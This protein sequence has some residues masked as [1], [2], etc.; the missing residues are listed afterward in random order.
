[1]F[2]YKDE[3]DDETKP[4]SIQFKRNR[5]T[6]TKPDADNLP[7][8]TEGT[9]QTNVMNSIEEAGE[10]VEVDI[11]TRNVETVS[12]EQHST[13]TPPSRPKSTSSK[14]NPST[15]KKKSTMHKSKMHTKPKEASGSDNDTEAPLEQGTE[16]SSDVNPVTGGGLEKPTA[17]DIPTGINDHIESRNS[18]ALLHSPA[19]KRSSIIMQRNTQR[20]STLYQNN[21]R[22]NKKRITNV[23]NLQHLD[24]GIGTPSKPADLAHK[25]IISNRRTMRSSSQAHV[26]ELRSKLLFMAHAKADRHH[27][28]LLKTEVSDEIPVEK[29]LSVLLN[30]P[31]ITCPD[32]DHVELCVVQECLN[33]MAIDVHAPKVCMLLHMLGLFFHNVL[34]YSD[35]AC[36][37]KGKVSRV[38]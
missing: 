35:V 16:T 21:A 24:G 30:N 14:R 5:T 33:K 31:N 12:I 6:D 20:A 2:V 28:E 22:N 10:E 23:T 9:P 38:C 34:M 1:M 25:S 19:R 17:I 4:D 3:I 36:C 8:V 7:A 37:E 27:R 29:C 15:R 18:T 26:A 13:P 11:I 32:F